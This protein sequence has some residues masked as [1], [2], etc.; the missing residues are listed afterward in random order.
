M[1][2]KRAWETY[3]STYRAREIK[4]LAGW[5]RAGESSSI[6]GPAGAGK[7]NLLGFLC[8][9]PEVIA[10]QLPFKSALVRVD[11]NN[12]PDRR[13]S[14]FYRIILRSLHEA[15]DQLAVTGD[16]L[17]VDV[18]TLYRKIE[19]KTDPFLAQSTLREALFL[20]KKAETRLV[21][22]LDPFDQFWRSAPTQMLD[23]LRGLRDGFK[24][25]LSYI[26]G[27]RREL[28][29]LRDPTQLHELH[30]LLDTYRCWL[31]PMET[32]DARWVI[33]QV[34][35]ATGQSFKEIQAE[36]LIE[37]TGGYPAMLKAAGLWLVKNWPGPEDLT[38]WKESLLAESS[39]QNRLKE[40]WKGL[41]GEEQAALSALQLALISD[42]KSKKSLLQIEKKYELI[43]ARLQAKNLCC[44]TEVCPELHPERLPGQAADEGRS[45]RAGWRIFSPLLTQFIATVR[46]S[47]IGRIRYNHKEDRFF[48][49]EEELIG[50]S[51][52]DRKLLRHFVEN[53]KIG[54]TVDNLIETV[55]DAADGVSN[56]SVQQAIHQ[57]RKKIEP[58]S[59]KPCYLVNERG[60]GYRFFPEGA[61]R[62]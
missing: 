56:W 58:V 62:G 13:L 20:F 50:L 53:S 49:G 5:I 15:Q 43:F 7:S 27:L 1:T 2:S 28:A 47:G 54:Y 24:T 41:S 42:K 9:Q 6:V 60:A 11:L 33:E 18:E 16:R 29:Y 55:W 51:E 12:L 37:L 38:T 22:V 59:G 30:E 14:T 3:P 4:T 31:G 61:P 19:D 36:R 25:T 10:K 52:Q 57:L 40:L 48:Q 39:I 21:L 45:R 44:K 8:H 32:E 46:G 17:P 26:V 34:E 23:N 35:T